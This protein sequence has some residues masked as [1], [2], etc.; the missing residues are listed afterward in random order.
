VEHLSF[1]S[2][3]VEEINKFKEKLEK[4][5]SAVTFRN[6]RGADISAA[7]GQLAGK[8]AARQ[9]ELLKN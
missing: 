3:T 8:S 2:P 9:N 1:Q 6:S 7:C 4:L 5:S